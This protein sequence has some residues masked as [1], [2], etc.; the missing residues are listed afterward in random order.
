MYRYGW[1][2]L[3]VWFSARLKNSAAAGSL[4]SFTTAF[5]GSLPVCYERQATLTSGPFVAAV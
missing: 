2:Q 3:A 4:T 5:G 1:Q